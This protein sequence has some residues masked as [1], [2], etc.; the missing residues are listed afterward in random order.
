MSLEDAFAPVEAYNRAVMQLRTWG[1]LAPEPSRKYQGCIIVAQGC[2]GDLIVVRDNF[3]G[4][5]N[6]PWY[7]DDLSDFLMSLPPGLKTGL[8]QFRGWYKKY[9]NGRGRFGGGKFE[10][11][12]MI[13]ETA[14]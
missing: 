10:P 4:L 14:S 7:Y 6:S 8:Y 1:H 3:D 2:Y 13:S 11:L 12:L 5:P 9:K